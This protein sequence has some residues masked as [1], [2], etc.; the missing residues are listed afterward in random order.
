MLF[1]LKKKPFSGVFSGIEPT[2][3]TWKEGGYWLSLYK[4]NY[5]F[6]RLRCDISMR[7]W[8]HPIQVYFLLRGKNVSFIGVRTAIP[9]MVFYLK[10]LYRPYVGMV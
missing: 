1:F 7:E 10:T 5:A 4:S 3:Y 2:A 9:I 8:A 6:N